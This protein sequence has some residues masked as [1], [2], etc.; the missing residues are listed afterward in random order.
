[1]NFGE[2]Q[3]AAKKTADYGGYG[4]LRGRAYA[5]SGLCG[6]A[7]ELANQFKKIIRDDNVTVTDERMHLIRDELGDVLWYCAAVAE[8]FGLSL[9]LIAQMNIAKLADRAERDAIHGDRRL[10]G[11]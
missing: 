11:H 8:E 6:E 3:R 10:G 1:M 7:G 5:V 2:Y 9:D 4:E